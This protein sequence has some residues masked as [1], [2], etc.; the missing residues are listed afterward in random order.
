MTEEERLLLGHLRDL[1]ER[2]S[3]SGIYMFS[4]FLS[5]P[6]QDLFLRNAREFGLTDYRLSGGYEGAERKI[7]VFGSEDEFGYPPELPISVLE[8]SP[9]SEK[10]CE[11]LSHRD[12]LGAM[13]SLQIDRSL[14]GDIIVRGKQAYVLS[15]TKSAEFLCGSLTRIRHT[16]VTVQIT[17]SDIPELRPVLKELSLNIASER[18]DSIVAGFTGISRS[19]VERLFHE[20][21]VFL[22]GRMTDSLSARPKEGDILTVRGFGKAVYCGISGSS[23][24]GRLYVKLNQYV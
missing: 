15:L 7:A 2:A 18:L 19:H 13:M 16:D 8:I 1:S 9:L 23:K 17:G 14:T 24:K 11:E 4:G 3:R 12:I 20:Q 10:Y 6:E 21:R 22:N 5:L